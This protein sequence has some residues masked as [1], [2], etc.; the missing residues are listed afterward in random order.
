MVN[1]EYL[2]LLAQGSSAWNLWRSE[3]LKESIDLQ[4]ANLEGFDLRVADLSGIDLRRANLTSADLG[5]VDL[6]RA[7]LSHVKL[8]RANLNGANLIATNLSSADLQDT[9]LRGAYLREAN[10]SAVNLQGADLK[11]ADLTLA[12]LHNALLQNALMTECNLTEATLVGANLIE[13]N[14]SKSDLTRADLS[15]A[16]LSGADLSRATMLETRL[17]GAKISGSRV[18]GVSAWDLDL[19]RA[20]Q[21][22]LIITPP[23]QHII[24]VDNIEL[25]QAVYL[26]MNKGMILDFLLEISSRTVLILGR[27]TM[28]RKAVLNAIRDELR[29]LD[30]MPIL[31]DFEIPPDRSLSEILLV[32]AQMS[33]FIIA[34]ISDP[35]NIPL[36]LS[37]V[38]PNTP[39]VPVQLIIQ[40]TQIPYS[41]IAEHYRYPQVLPIYRYENTEQLLESLMD[42]VIAPAEKKA[43][44]IETR[45]REFERRFN[46]G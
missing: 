17:S 32:L 12:L 30:Y 24:T 42:S 3:R 41:M 8:D 40:S 11:N 34:D 7:D 37:T 36:E 2:N 15:D 43:N 18:Y 21:K 16:N 20:I 25:A 9:S 27:F 23:D 33:R 6:G 1:E 45:R 4:E 26:L 14:L 38:I 39:S 13:A 31:M 46:L 19:S 10:L 44:E 29:Q 5:G 22:D 28:E 35:L